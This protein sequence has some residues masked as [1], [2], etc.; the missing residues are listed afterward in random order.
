MAKGPSIFC[1]SHKKGKLTRIGC[2]E[3]LG[4]AVCPHSA[5]LKRNNVFRFL[6]PGFLAHATVCKV[7]GAIML[8]LADSLIIPFD[9]MAM[10]EFVEN[11]VLITRNNYDAYFDEDKLGEN[12]IAVGYK[13]YSC[14]IKQFDQ[15]P[16]TVYTHVASA[17]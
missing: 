14:R 15:K 4:Y 6:D 8:R 9:L 17:I 16:S 13:V 5:V 12:R 2:S 1:I 11:Q 10:A 3:P 7:S